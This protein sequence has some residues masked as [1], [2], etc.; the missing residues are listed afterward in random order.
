MELRMYHDFASSP[1]FYPSLGK[2]EKRMQ[3]AFGY[4]GFFTLLGCSVY[5]GIKMIGWA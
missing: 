1:C 5:T 4:L 3:G 2:P